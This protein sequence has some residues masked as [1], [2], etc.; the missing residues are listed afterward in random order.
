MRKITF[1]FLILCYQNIYC[2]NIKDKL[3]K[4]TTIEEAQK[5]IEDNPELIPEVF[6]ISPEIDTLVPAYFNTFKAGNII[7]EN[8]NTFKVISITK[9]KAL[10]VSYIYLDG[11]KLTINEIN[12]LRPQIIKQYK[13][14][15]KFTDL[16][17]KYTMDGNI[18]ADLNWFTEDMM[19]PEFVNAIKIH[20]KGDIFTVDVPENKWY[21][22]TLKTHRDKEVTK[23]TMLKIKS[24]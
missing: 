18:K 22:V 4:V 14:G 12:K 8:G 17:K 24:S 6:N 11:S 20:K 21:Y 13:K 9:E 10:R 15:I 19:V 16:A 3:D 2:Q 23:I 1:L 5:F 7:S